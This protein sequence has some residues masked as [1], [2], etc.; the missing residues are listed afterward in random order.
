MQ[1]GKHKSEMH[2]IYIGNLFDKKISLFTGKS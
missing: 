2:I 1:I